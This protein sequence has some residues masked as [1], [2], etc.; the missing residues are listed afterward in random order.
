M[1]EGAFALGAAHFG[2]NHAVARVAMFAHRAALGGR[3]VARPARP[4]VIFGAA[5]EQRRAASGATID[6]VALVVGIFAGERPLGAAF[7]QH[8][9]SHRIER[10]GGGLFG[11]GIGHGESP[12]YGPFLA[13]ACRSE[14]QRGGKE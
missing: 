3:G 6:A 10:L 13:F 9:M 12:S 11:F 8:M 7:A 1:A 5:V 2:A 4:A 14:E